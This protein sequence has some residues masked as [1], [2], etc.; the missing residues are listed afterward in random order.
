MSESIPI[1]RPWRPRGAWN[2]QSTYLRGDVV[3]Q[4]GSSFV[5]IAAQSGQQP[6]SDAWDL[7]AASGAVGEQ[8]PQGAPGPQG[9]AGQSSTLS[10]GTG[11]DSD[12]IEINGAASGPHLIGPQGVQGPQGVPGPQGSQGSQGAAG[13]SPALSWGTGTDSDRIEINGAASGPHL[14]GP[15]GA[16]GPQGVQGPQG[17]QGPQGLITLPGTVIRDG[18]TGL[19]SSVALT[20]GATYRLT[21]TNGLIYSLSDGTHTWTVSRDGNGQITGWSVV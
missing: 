9:S 14:T 17:P 19:I 3:S 6:P 5:C 15:Q 13:P 18:T 2:S 7:L 8:G 20:G 11:T 21:R 10:W 16:Q 4:G 12:R 1:L